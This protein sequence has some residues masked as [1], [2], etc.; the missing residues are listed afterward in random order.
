[1]S[2][3]LLLSYKEDIL[4]NVGGGGNNIWAKPRMFIM[5]GSAPGSNTELYLYRYRYRYR[6]WCEWAFKPRSHQAR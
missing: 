1:M 6:A 3:F 5:S 2:F 4:K